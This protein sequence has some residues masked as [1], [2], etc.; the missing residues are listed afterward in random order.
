MRRTEPISRQPRCRLQ[1]GDA[2]ARWD[3]PRFGRDDSMDA[4]ARGRGRARGRRLAKGADIEDEARGRRVLVY[5]HRLATRVTHWLNAIAILVLLMTGANILMAHP[6]LYWGARGSTHDAAWAEVRA[7]GPTQRGLTRIGGWTWDTTG[8]LGWSGGEGRTFPAWATMPG[9]RNLALARNWHFAA[10]WLLILNGLAYWLF[11]LISRHVPRNLVPTRADIRPRA[12]WRDFV[13][14]L[15]LNYPKGEDSLHYHPMQKLAYFAVIAVLVPGVIAT[16]LC[17]S[18]GASAVAPWI[19]DLLGGRQSAR[20]LHFLFA[21]AILGFL[22]VHVVQV[23]LAGVW[24]E[25][26][27]MVTGK[28]AITPEGTHA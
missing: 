19:V 17:M 22:I 20:S 8:V 10:A 6:R 18:P 3:L 1:R 25:I 21:S 12:I 28:W 15:K 14:H 5:R 24:N 9:D 11:G 4:H 16:G 2:R 13:E 23:I 27:S 26:R 7:D